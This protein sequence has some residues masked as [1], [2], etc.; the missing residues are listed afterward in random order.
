MHL[1]QSEGNLTTKP[2]QRSKKLFPFSS[3]CSQAS[4]EN[5]A[6]RPIPVPE[7][8]DFIFSKRNKNQNCTFLLATSK[9]SIAIQNKL[10]SQTT[11]VSLFTQQ[12][13]FPKVCH[14]SASDSGT[15]LINNEAA[16]GRPMLS[17]LSRK[18][19]TAAYCLS[20]ELYFLQCFKFA[21][22]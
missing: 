9:Y 10:N 8:L 17:N 7:L 22:I 6:A 3:N 19:K 20:F 15:I 11:P 5:F 2:S 16:T 13:C 12:S 4:H 14:R 18:S 1:R 21:I